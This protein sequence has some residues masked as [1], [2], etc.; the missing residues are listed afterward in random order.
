MRGN[1]EY[2]ASRVANMCQAS[3]QLP[4]EKEPPRMRES[5]CLSL[6]R[7]RAKYQPTLDNHM[8]HSTAAAIHAHII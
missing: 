6:H 3:T 5:Q 2:V 7:A 8:I 1:T 4:K